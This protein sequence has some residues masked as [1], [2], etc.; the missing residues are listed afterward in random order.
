MQAHRGTI[1]LGLVALGLSQLLIGLWAMLDTSGWFDSFPGVRERL[2]SARTVLTTTTW[3]STPAAVFAATGVMLILAAA[4][5]GPPAR[6]GRPDL[7]PGLPDPAHGFHL[8]GGRRSANG[9]PRRQQRRVG[10]HDA[11]AAA[12]AVACSRAAAGSQPSARSGAGQRRGQDRAPHEGHARAVRLVVRAPRIRQRGHPRAESSPTIRSLRWAMADSS[13]RLDHSDAV[14]AKLKSLGEIKAATVVN[15][16]WCM[17]FGSMIGREHGVSDE[18]LSRDASPSRE[19]GV[20][21]ARAP[22]ARLRDR[23]DAAL[24]PRSTTSCSPA[25][26]SISTTP[27]WSS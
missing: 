5:D 6:P 2:A 16:E 22:G 25:C 13:W 4:L 8:G 20:R 14:P 9:R 15:C 17:D 7:L 10:I 27:S 24:P 11:V 18:Q 19:P 26:A 1:R 23:D 21:R 3:H 12:T